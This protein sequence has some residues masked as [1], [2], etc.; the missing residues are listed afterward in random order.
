MLLSICKRR[1]LI[2]FVQL[3][4]QA[5]TQLLEDT[6]FGIQ[7]TQDMLRSRVLLQD[8]A[9]KGECQGEMPLLYIFSQR[10]ISGRRSPVA[11]TISSSM[12]SISPHLSFLHGVAKFYDADHNQL[13]VASP[14]A[15]STSS[16]QKELLLMRQNADTVSECKHPI[17]P[18]Y[19]LIYFHEGL[20]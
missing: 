9:N 16:N 19:S 13:D 5:R 15:L 1:I 11:G 12:R 10:Y 18:L 2:D 6:V 14:E 8:K 20:G 4:Q 3:S 17:L 7:Q